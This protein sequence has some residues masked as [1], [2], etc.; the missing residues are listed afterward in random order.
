VK[1]EA[2]FGLFVTVNNTSR[3]CTFNEF[4]SKG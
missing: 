4:E 1:A 3:I 2:K